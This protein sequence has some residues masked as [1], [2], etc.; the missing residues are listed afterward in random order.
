MIATV[1][2]RDHLGNEDI[3]M[4]NTIEVTK[5]GVL[6]VFNDETSAT[7]TTTVTERFLSGPR[8]TTTTE[9]TRKRYVTA[10]YPKGCWS[11]AYSRC[12]K[13]EPEISNVPYN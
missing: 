3:L 10:S 1:V 4:A 5:A 12:T 8:T 9:V 11:A 13:V 2:I 7:T 6:M